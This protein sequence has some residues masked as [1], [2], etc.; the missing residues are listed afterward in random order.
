[1]G[2]R[3]AP[4]K[5]KAA[6]ARASQTPLA[7]YRAKRDFAKTAEPAGA[8]PEG[9]TSARARPAPA[10]RFVVQRHWARRAH[11]DFR[12]EWD[13]VLK[14][15]AVT[16]GPSARP[17]TKRLAVRTEDHPLEYSAFEG[18]IPAGEYGGGDVQ[19]WD[20]GPCEILSDPREGFAK[21]VLKLRLQGQRMKGDWALVRLKTRAGDKR[22]NWLLLKDRDAFAEDDDSLAD[23]FASSVASW[24]TRAQIAAGETPR[25][26]AGPK[27]AK[28]GSLPQAKT[29][30]QEHA[31]QSAQQNAPRFV[32]PQ[33]CEA[34]ASAPK[35]ADWLHEMKYDG[36]RMQIVLERGRARLFTRQGHDWTARLPALKAAAEKL[37][38]DSAV[39]DGEAVVFDAGGLSDFPAL[40]AA[41][42]R[43][44]GS[45][46]GPISYVAFDLLHLDGEDLRALPLL[47]RKARLE[48]LLARKPDALSYASHVIGE[49]P[50]VFAKAVAAG[51]EGIVSKRVNLPYRSGRGPGWAKVKDRRREDVTVIGW[52]PSER[53]RAFAALVVA[54]EEKGRLIYAGRVGAGFDAR[55]Q[56]ELM[57]HLR[58]LARKQPPD[59]ERLDLAP[60]GVRWAE[61]GLIV[62]AAMAGWT[63]DG[64][65]RQGAFLGVREDRADELAAARARA[66]PHARAAPAQTPARGDPPD[67]SRLTHPE[68]VLYPQAGVTKLQLAEYL[69][70]VAPRLMPHLARR[71]VSFV[72]APEG[73]AGARFFQ[74]HP[75]RGMSRGLAS[76]SIGHER[77]DYLMIESEE[78]LVTCAQFGVLEIHGWSARADDIER[79]DRLVFDLDPDEDLPFADV[80]AGALE[81]RDLLAAAGLKSFAMVS[82]GKGVHVIAPLAPERDWPQIEAFA[83]GFAQRLARSAPDRWV[84]TMT[85]ARR[86]GKIFLDY[87]RNKRSATAI[88]PWS[89]RARANASLAM[90]VSWRELARLERADGFVLSEALNR[91]DALRAPFRDP[92]RDF[93]TLDQ[94][95]S[96]ETM[97][98][99]GARPRG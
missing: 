83:Q 11:F 56:D 62:E 54:R 37:S 16:K 59:V 74:R 92:W 99:A 21:G 85:K 65:V 36:Y 40:A 4:R 63:G 17:G 94:R 57:R 73:L 87:L 96:D 5:A 26:G 34:R 69:L 15:W 72:R 60:R 93:F 77:R 91:R 39:L 88:A 46:A 9:E 55:A 18:V 67:L 8:S 90:P 78:G 31:Q 35:G 95:L 86:K 29:K 51:A 2:A 32:P 80:A 71:P 33:L 61:P 89:P 38:A 75:L 22:E 7:A 28:G 42:K 44:A 25:P 12:F 66:R 52:T 68:R 47:E 24:R 27:A 41:L 48:K 3:A 53:G 6:S 14:S 19:L 64:L 23:R 13:G 49:G 79:P 58:A 45:S 30:P 84:A 50:A 1:M 82:G 81:V 70:A 98:V 43:G 20:R 76:L 10:S 97:R